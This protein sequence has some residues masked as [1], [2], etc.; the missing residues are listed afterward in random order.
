MPEENSDA[1]VIRYLK[2]LTIPFAA[3]RYLVDYGYKLSST[4]VQFTAFQVSMSP[5]YQSIEKKHIMHF[6]NRFN[7]HF[8]LSPTLKIQLTR[9]MDSMASKLP[10]RALGVV[11]AEALIM[12]LAYASQTRTLDKLGAAYARLEHVSIFQV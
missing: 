6:K 7:Q 11:H 1:H 10:D 3:V 4:N 12:A 8:D 5:N 9:I 2:T